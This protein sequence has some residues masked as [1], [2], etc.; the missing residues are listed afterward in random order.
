MLKKP[1]V[2]HVVPLK[3]V[4]EILYPLRDLRKL[5][6]ERYDVERAKYDDHPARR[7]IPLA[8]VAKLNCV[9]EETLNFAPVHPRVIY[10]AWQALGVSLKPVLWFGIPLER[11]H[12]LPAV[13]TLPEVERG[14]GADHGDDAVRWLEP[15]HYRELTALPERT[16]VWYR[17]LVGEKKRGGWFVGVPHVLVRG[18]VS[19]AGLTPF[20]WSLPESGGL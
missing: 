6:P 7:K 16:L 15:E 8:R 2:Y 4:G 12:G 18:P 19:V 9:Y 1:R 11:L 3:L 10:R 14:V 13:V 5:S 20:D 17:Q